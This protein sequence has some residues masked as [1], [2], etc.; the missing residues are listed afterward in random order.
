ME[1]KTFLITFEKS[2]IADGF[3]NE[4]AR[5]H[6]L[7]IAKSLKDSDKA[8]IHSMQ[9]DAPIVRMAKNYAARVRAEEAEYGKSDI[10][11]T[12]IDRQFHS[13]DETATYQTTPAAEQIAVKERPESVTFRR[14]KKSAASNTPHATTQKLDVVK[15]KPQK[16]KLTPEGRSLYTKWVFSK[17]IPT[18]CAVFFAA[19]ASFAVYALIAILIA[20]LVAVLVAIAAI[21]CVCTLAGFI[22]GIIKL[23]SVV[24][25]GVYEIGLSLLILGITLASSI[26]IYNLALRIVPILWKRFSEFLRSKRYAL[27]ER[28]NLIRTECNGQ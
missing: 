6:T 17:G 2:L 4:S 25:E 21:G 26:G 15:S 19:I 22:Y 1:V 20:S 13:A 5:Q 14:R 24:P 3:N 7:K 9:S 8:K 12:T 18:W 27:R 28:L 23:F 10:N 16:V 11:T